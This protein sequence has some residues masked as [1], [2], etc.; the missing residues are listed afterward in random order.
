[1]QSA[2]SVTTLINLNFF[3]DGSVIPRYP[4]SCTN[5]IRP[6]SDICNTDLL[7]ELDTG[8][9]PIKTYVYHHFFNYLARLL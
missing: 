6:D 9:K 1:M 5:K 4:K 2:L 3:N 8:N 7:Q